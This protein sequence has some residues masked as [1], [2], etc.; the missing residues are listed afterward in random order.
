AS[1]RLAT[2]PQEIERL[3]AEIAKLTGLLDDPDLYTRAPETF[4]KASKALA[5]RQEKLS[6]AEEE[7]LELEAAREAAEAP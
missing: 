6:A 2:L 5:E 3:E 4:A 7:W 1:H